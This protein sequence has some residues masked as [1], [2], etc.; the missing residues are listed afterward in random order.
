MIGQNTLLV[1]LL[2]VVG[3]ISGWVWRGRRDGGLISRL[4]AEVTRSR[5]HEA[6]IAERGL[7]VEEVQGRYIECNEQ[8]QAARSEVARLDRKSVV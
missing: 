2:L 5:V 6:V 7:R 8:L 4:E 1:F 3:V